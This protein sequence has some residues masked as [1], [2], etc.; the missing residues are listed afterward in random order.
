MTDRNPA[1]ASSKRHCDLSLDDPTPSAKLQRCSEPSEPTPA[2]KPNGGAAT[3]EESE[4][5][6]GARNPRAQRYLVAV[7]YI[8]TRFSGSQKQPNQRTV[9]GVLEEAFHRFIGQPVSIIFSS[10]TDAGVHA[11][12]NVCHVDVERISK[13]KPGEVVCTQNS[14]FFLTLI[15]DQALS[16]SLDTLNLFL[17]LI[18]A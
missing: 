17:F 5:M 2:G 4:M 18:F 8:G 9:T 13:R 14:F 1:A 12:S 7:E 10:R 11:L 15:T 6:A 3:G 16:T